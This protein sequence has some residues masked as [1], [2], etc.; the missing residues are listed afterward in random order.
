MTKKA[1]IING[2]KS[3]AHSHGKLNTYL[4][5]VAADYFKQLT[6]WE[7]LTT[8][9]ANGYDCDEEVEK[10]LQADLILWQTPAW[11]MGV[12]W[13]T[14]KYIDEV[15]TAGHEKLYQNDGRTRKDP[16]R[17]YGSGGLLPNKHYMLAVTWNA[18]KEAFTEKDQFFEG[19]GIDAVYFPLH[20]A[21]QFLGM[22]PLPTYIFN[23]VIKDP[24]IERDVVQYRRHLEKIALSL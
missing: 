23:D 15:F 1:F 4:A 19:K 10:F 22:K 14:K 21:N 3:Y 11:W 5:N 17:K 13:E 24:Q 8:N 7:I 2:G 18:P 12:P 6:G 20:K 16:T 9:I